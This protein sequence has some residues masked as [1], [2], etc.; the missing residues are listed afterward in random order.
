[1]RQE[2]PLAS[3]ELEASDIRETAPGARPRLKPNA[4]HAFD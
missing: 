3:T 1:M 2:K 4:G